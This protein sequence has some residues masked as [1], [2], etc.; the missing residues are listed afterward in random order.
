MALDKDGGQI[1]FG[2]TASSVDAQQDFERLAD[3]AESS[4][5]RVEDAFEKDPFA[6]MRLRLADMKRRADDL[7]KSTDGVADGLDKAGNSAR[8][9]S[10]GFGQLV[11]S[12]GEGDIGEILG[13]IAQQAGPAA[14][15][16]AFVSLA[17]VGAAV[18]VGAMSKA[19]IENSREVTKLGREYKLT[20][21]QIQSL[22]S[23][24]VIT[25]E[26]VEDLAE[27]FK[28][29]APQ[30]KIL[31]KQIKDTGAEI[32]EGLRANTRKAIIEFEGLHVAATG[33]MN[34]IVRGA[35][36]GVIELLKETN[37]LLA[38][39]R[40]LWIGIG[41]AAGAVL[42]FVSAA[43]RAA[44]QALQDYRLL[45]LDIGTLGITF[46]IRS[47]QNFQNRETT[48]GVDFG[49]DPLDI[50]NIKKGK[51][52]GAGKKDITAL[53]EEIGLLEVQEKAIQRLAK[54][55]IE[56]AKAEL[57]A[58]TQGGSIDDK[59]AA[60]ER[61]AETVLNAENEMAAAR[62]KIVAKQIEETRKSDLLPREKNLKLAQLREEQ[63][64]IEAD[65]NQKVMALETEMNEARAK[66]F[67][68]YL[69]LLRKVDEAETR[70]LE[71]MTKKKVKELQALSDFNARMAALFND[72]KR[73][74]YEIDKFETDRLERAGADPL[75]IAE[76]RSRGDA[77]Q[78]N[79]SF[80]AAQASIRRER[81]QNYL[82]ALEGLQTYEQYILRLEALDK[83]EEAERRRHAEALKEISRLLQVDAE[84][85]NPLSA[86][87]ILGDTFA[88]ALDA[89]GS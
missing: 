66:L 1:K 49:P 54:A 68:D 85:L 3:K 57:A 74:E 36:P 22:Q 73:I 45:L 86:R 9:S 12:L 19:V 17:F 32:D 58:D 35:L 79:E 63:L 75:K 33:A 62:D 41:N 30:A 78:E 67:D 82:D 76:R 84:N 11:E 53:R 43:V 48:G 71:E 77:A 87:S 61:Y 27:N 55:K 21:I 15:G 59:T 26:S 80:R 50:P 2:I 83:L 10:G 72:R 31:E 18:A 81:E 46:A 7:T 65:H 40:D 13:E 42:E 20:G 4:S 51:S 8:R 28:K 39:N 47:A 64:K 89:T 69:E 44:N 88:D 24:A 60:Y 5:R 23:L 56:L 38:D 70:H 6:D 29:V 37:A 34:D 52:G 14:F 16:V 25:G